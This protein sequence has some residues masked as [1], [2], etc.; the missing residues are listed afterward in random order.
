[1]LAV[2]IGGTM[3]TSAVRLRRSAPLLGPSVPAV[4]FVGPGEQPAV[5]RPR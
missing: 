1:M 4:V 2:D 3:A 5:E